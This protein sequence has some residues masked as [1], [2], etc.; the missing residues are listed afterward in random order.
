MTTATGWVV[1]VHQL[2][3]TATTLYARAVFK[4]TRFF[5]VF[6][7][8][9]ARRRATNAEERKVNLIDMLKVM[10]KCC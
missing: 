6:N 9:Q 10:T 7:V 1:L 3:A 8:H 2:V 5:T 4:S